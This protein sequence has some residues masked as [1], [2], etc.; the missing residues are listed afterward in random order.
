MRLKNKV[1]VITGASRGIGKSI[2]EYYAAEGARLVISARDTGRLGAFRDELKSRGTE[3]ISVTADVSK[4]SDVVTLV[5]AAI[6]AFGRIDIL[7]NNAGFGIFKPVVE[8]KTEEFDSLFNV[9]MRGT[10]IATRETLPHMI[11][12]KD[13]VI[14]NI[15]SLAGKNAVENGAAY[16]ATKWAVLGFARSLML[17]VRKHNIR[18]VTICPGSV[19]TDFGSGNRPNRDRILK[20]ADVAEAAVL[21]ASLPATAMMSEIDLRPTNPK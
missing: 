2:A 14:I 21:A 3:V 4:E 17:E 11:A 20:P 8:M 15:A 18:V 9:N 12:E 7:V 6:G 10:F 13:G 1:A 16:A 5:K 19:D